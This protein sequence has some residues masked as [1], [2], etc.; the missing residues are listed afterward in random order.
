MS[1]VV[2]H[3][4]TGCYLQAHDSW[5]NHLESAMHFNS[6]LRLVDYIEHGGVHDKLDC[7]EVVVIPPH[8]AETLVPANAVLPA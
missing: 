1:L 7:I 4:D 5:T 6:G 3:K 2:R 8:S